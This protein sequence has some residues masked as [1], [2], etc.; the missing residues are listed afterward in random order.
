MLNQILMHHIRD[1]LPDIKNR[2]TGMMV[3]GPLSSLR[4][5]VFFSLLLYFKIDINQEIDALG[6]PADAMN[7]FVRARVH[8]IVNL[9]FLC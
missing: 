1:C 7:G 8:L 4:H 9:T 2:I 3:S 6:A 5:S